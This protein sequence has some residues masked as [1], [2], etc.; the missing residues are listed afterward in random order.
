[1]AS[2]ETPSPFIQ[3]GVKIV[4]SDSTVTVEEV[5]L[6]KQ[7]M[8]LYGVCQLRTV[9]STF[10]VLSVEIW[11]T[12]A[13]CVHTKSTMPGLWLAHPSA[14]GSRTGPAVV[15]CGVPGVAAGATGLHCENNELDSVEE[16]QASVAAE[17]L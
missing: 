12:N 10:N 13:L 16:S 7:V 14:A 8:A 3:Q 6:V 15:D 4:L 2:P 17:N 9:D 1:M 5:L 11:D